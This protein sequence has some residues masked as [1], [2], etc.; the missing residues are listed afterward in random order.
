MKKMV[1]T[2]DGPA[3]AG[4]TTVSRMLADRLGYRYIDTGALY[5][6]IA[7]AV[8]EGGIDSKD[9]AALEKMCTALSQ[10]YIQT[11]KGPRLLSNGR[12]VTERLRTPEITMLASAVSARPVVRRFLMDVQRAMGREEGAVFEGRDMGTVVFPDAD[13]KFYLDA[14]E[15]IRAMRR[16][17]ELKPKTELTFEEVERD[18]LRR[19]KNDS[20]RAEAPL[21]PAVDA[22][23]IDSADL[24][25]AEV[26]AVMLGHIERLTEN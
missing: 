3:G 6:A 8:H 12:D 26:V 11:E 4:K 16:F 13:V 18:L 19:D 23:R 24:A 10:R 7:L 1:V 21:K 15:K 20:T 22:I 5:R 9:D 25:P 17:L 14:P 2:I